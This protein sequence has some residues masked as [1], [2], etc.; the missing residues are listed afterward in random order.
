[1]ATKKSLYELVEEANGEIYTLLHDQLSPKQKVILDDML[2]LTMY[3]LQ[4]EHSEN[5]VN[6]VL[7]ALANCRRVL[8][9]GDRIIFPIRP[10]NNGRIFGMN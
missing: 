2:T 8:A 7:E 1:M 10:V 3:Q 6:G 5:S 9:F 4:P